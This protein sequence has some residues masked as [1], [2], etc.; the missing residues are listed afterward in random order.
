MLSDLEHKTVLGVSD[1]KGVENGG[2][3]TIELHVH[4]GTNDLGNSSY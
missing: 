2:E 4:D 3:S 1:L